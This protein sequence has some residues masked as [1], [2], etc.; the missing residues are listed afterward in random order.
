MK[1]VHDWRARC[2]GAFGCLLA[3]GSASAE[4]CAAPA[5]QRALNARVLQTELMVTA[6][7][8]GYRADYNAFVGTFRAELALRGGALRAYFA[9]RYGA[10]AEDELNRFVTRLANQ[11]SARSNESRAK[12]CSD[13]AALFGRL[14]DA[15]PVKFDQLVDAPAFALSH[16]VPACASA[17]AR[18]AVPVAATTLQTG[19]VAGDLPAQ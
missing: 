14:A 9:R 16:G 10:R 1:P 5:E 6:L 18:G 11:E 4:S 13:G 3:V 19:D 2:A 8:C 15:T 17:S 12:F 7:A